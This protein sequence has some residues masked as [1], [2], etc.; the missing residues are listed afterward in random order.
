MNQRKRKQRIFKESIG[1][2]FETAVEQIRPE[3]MLDRAQS[4]GG[5]RSTKVA[6]SVRGPSRTAGPIERKLTG[7]TVGSF[8]RRVSIACVR[9]IGFPPP[10]CTTIDRS[11]RGDLRMYPCVGW[12]TSR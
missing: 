1:E 6:R 4:Y 7:R 3:A 8:F 5:I 10:P 2:S 11:E 12:S 9:S